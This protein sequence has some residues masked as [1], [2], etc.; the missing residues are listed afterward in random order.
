LSEPF[1]I[2]IVEADDTVTLTLAGELDLSGVEAFDSA[3]PAIGPGVRAVVIDLAD[4]TFI[5]SSGI[6]CFIR[7]RTAALEAGSTLVLRSPSPLVRKVLDVVDL[8]ESIEI[9]D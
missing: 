5:D 3:L 6:A 7:A 9:T 4:V 1:A 2:S 8:G